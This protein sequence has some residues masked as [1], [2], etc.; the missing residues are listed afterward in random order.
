[1]DY[2]GLAPSNVRR[3]LKRLR[4]IQ[5]IEKSKNLYRLTEFMKLSEIFNSIIKKIVLNS[6]TERVED[7]ILL[8]EQLIGNT[9]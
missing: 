2:K 4:D 1:M 5:I 3:Q 8:Y 9:E 6:I 7:Y